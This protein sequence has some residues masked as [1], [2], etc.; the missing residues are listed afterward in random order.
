VNNT[1]GVKNLVPSQIGYLQT[2]EKFVGSGNINKI[3]KKKKAEKNIK[4]V[5]KNKSTRKNISHKQNKKKDFNFI[6]FTKN[7]KIGALITIILLILYIL[8]FS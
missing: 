4:E 6:D 2:G 5:V 8:L 3:N 7:E 1:L